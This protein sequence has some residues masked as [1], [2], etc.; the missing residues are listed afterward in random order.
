MLTSVAIKTSLAFAELQQ[1]STIIE[2]KMGLHFPPERFK[3]LETGFS[4]AARDMGFKDSSEC[5]SNI[6]AKELCH[7]EIE[8]F[9]KYL[10][11]G[12]T[13]FFR[14]PERLV[15]FESRI[16]SQLIEQRKDS[17]RKIRIWCAGCSSGEEP[18]TI[19]ILL[20]KLIPDIEKWDITIL[21]TDI[22]PKVLQRARKGVY[23][24]WS[25]RGNS[26]SFKLEFFKRLSN[27]QFELNGEIKRMVTFSHLNL[28]NNKFAE[29]F[30]RGNAVDIIF[31]RNVLMYFGEISIKRIVNDF[32]NCLTDSGWLI[33]S[34]VE[35][36]LVNQS[37]FTPVKYG[38]SNFYRKDNIRV[39]NN[40]NVQIE[41]F[42][43]GPL[44]KEISKP[45]KFY[46]EIS[47]KALLSNKV[48]VPQLST[49][50]PS[51]EENSIYNKGRL[52]FEQGDYIRT[53]HLLSN[54]QSG[55]SSG[56]SDFS[57]NPDLMLLLARSYANLGQLE[58]AAEY[59]RKAVCLNKSNKIYHFY[60][61]VIMQEIGKINEAIKL[62]KK[63]IY[64]DPDYAIVHF[65]LGLLMFNRGEQRESKKYL[66][67]TLEILHKREKDEIV[68]DSEGIS[69]W[70][71][72]AIV[73]SL[74][75]K[76]AI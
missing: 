4:L 62:Y 32:Y 28:A 47:T 46:Q 34:L 41:T 58:S 71:L 43:K 60:H 57:A 65:T 59:I 35:S 53:V 33:V 52:S 55:S 36:N 8:V 6:S 26:N 73:L 64:L 72:R 16:L 70:Q 22:N 25:F 39:K 69:A 67:N 75:N 61:G 17:G 27:N 5:L 10:T 50:E 21:A 2:T 48:I 30:A 24:S 49:K 68:D 74:R 31:C 11:T 1:L 76:I 12:E 23:G 18:Y 9:A 14:E 13:Y 51:G 40:R 66:E 20:K 37:A 54:L 44:L 19:A 45:T 15:E 63:A 3:D 29:Q 42:Q 56:S 7:E 38:Q